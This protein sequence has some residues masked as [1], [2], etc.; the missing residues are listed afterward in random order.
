[1]IR[2]KTKNVTS[3]NTQQ[4]APTR[5]TIIGRLFIIKSKITDVMNV[6]CQ[7]VRNM[8]LTCIGYARAI[9]SEYDYL[10]EQI[11]C[12]K[13][14]GCSLIFSEIVRNYAIFLK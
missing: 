12:L 6:N 8:A 3:V 4:N 7:A 13:N 10:K 2:L 5:Y 14:E 1:M 9:H 11:K